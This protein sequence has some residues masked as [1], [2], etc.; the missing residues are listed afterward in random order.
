MPITEA[1]GKGLYSYPEA[2]RL[3]GISAR[4]VRDW[5]E[6]PVA[7][8]F[9]HGRVLQGDYQTAGLISFLDLI[10]VTVAGHMRELG[11]SLP[12]VRKARA[13]LEIYLHTH[14]PFSH[15]DLY[16]DGRKVFVHLA[17]A[18]QKD[19]ELIEVVSQQHAIPEVLMPYLKRVDYD[20]V[21]NLARQWNIAQ[22][23]V[24]DPARS[25]GK[26]IVSNCAIPTSVL[27]AAYRANARNAEAVAEWYSV[28]A[29][30]VQAAIQFEHAYFGAAA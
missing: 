9:R 27:A 24:I 15:R 28:T 26:P 13:S 16:T 2:A 19:P 3:T 1:L 20:T 22:G 21:S 10:E 23:V 29:E 7:G 18:A 25:F 6:A 5:F 14:H 12:S 8:T 30:D 4:R 11:I 17:K